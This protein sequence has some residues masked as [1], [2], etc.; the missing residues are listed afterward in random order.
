MAIIPQ[1]DLVFYLLF[2]FDVGIQGTF[3]SLYCTKHCPESSYTLPF[4]SFSSLLFL[5]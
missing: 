3:F 5:F 1:I 2:L 4:F